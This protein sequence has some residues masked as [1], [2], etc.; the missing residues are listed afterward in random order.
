MKKII[1]PKPIDKSNFS[2]F[3]D[4][5]TTQDIKPIKINNGYAERFDGIAN[6]DTKYQEGE[7]TISIFSAL[8]RD[9]PMRIDMMEKHPMGSQA[10]IP[11]K[12]TTFLA[13][14]APKGDKPEIEKIQSFIIPPG[15]GINYKVGIWHFPL[16]ST[17]DM[18]F[19]VVDRKGSGDNLVIEDL[20]KYELIL[21]FKPAV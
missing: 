9:F 3:G 21:D 16:I 18:N 15:I 20:N 13:F 14:V 7:T 10:F 1:S 11:M 4:V 17:E 8:K 6:L 5:I 19:L 12:E 2:E